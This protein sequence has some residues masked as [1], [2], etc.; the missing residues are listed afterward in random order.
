MI[1]YSTANGDPTDE[2]ELILARTALA[3]AGF[4]DYDVLSEGKSVGRLFKATAAA[5]R[6][7]W[8]WCLGYG[9]H[10]ERWP[11]SG[12]EPTREDAMAA[13]RKS[14]LRQ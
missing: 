2:P 13:F 12:Y 1:D 7:P 9:H 6:R 3:D 8:F 11:I 10:R 5:P 4:E 14:W